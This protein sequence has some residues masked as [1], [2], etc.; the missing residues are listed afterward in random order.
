MNGLEKYK[1]GQIE[2]ER[3]FR[4]LPYALAL[5]TKALITLADAS[6]GIVSNI[7]YNDLTKFLTVNPAPGVTFRRQ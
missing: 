5:L 6:T 3:P 2:I 7:S 1:Q 4:G